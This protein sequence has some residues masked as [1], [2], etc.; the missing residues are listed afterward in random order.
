MDASF[1]GEVARGVVWP[2]E[3]WNTLLLLSIGVPLKG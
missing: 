1:R 3:W 2:E